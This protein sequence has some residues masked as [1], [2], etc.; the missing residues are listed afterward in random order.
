MCMK[1]V[2]ATMRCFDSVLTK[3]NSTIISLTGPFDTIYGKFENGKVSIPYFSILTEIAIMGTA[4]EDNKKENPVENDENLHFTIRLTKCDKNPENRMGLDLDSFDIDLKEHKKEDN[5][6]LACYQFYNRLRI[7]KVNSIT[8]PVFDTGKYVLK[9]LV[10]NTG[11]PDDNIIQSMT[12]FTV[13]LQE[14]DKCK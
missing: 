12:P 13:V 4:S 6:S 8:F 9:I 7:T 10:N 11:N 14:N 3:D 1:Y 5:L 2:N